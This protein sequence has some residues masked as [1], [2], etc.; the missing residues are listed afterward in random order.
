MH[1]Q[2][3]KRASASRGN[4]VRETLGNLFEAPLKSLVHQTIMVSKGLGLGRGLGGPELKSLRSVFPVRVS[5][6]RNEM[7]DWL[8]IYSCNSRREIDIDLNLAK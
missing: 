3:K 4:R 2:T 5:I 7:L 6:A 8:N 1:S